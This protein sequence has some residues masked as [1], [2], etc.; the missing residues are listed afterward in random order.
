MMRE[1]FFRDL[2]FYDKDNLPD[3][4]FTDL[5]RYYRRA[6]FVPEYI[7]LS[8]MAAAALCKWMRA[9]YKYAEICRNM[10]P[11]IQQLMEAEEELNKAQAILGEKRVAANRI[12]SDLENRIH[13]HKEA[14][15]KAKQIE[16]QI[17]V[18]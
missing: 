3:D 7:G 5:G 16:K 1:N 12:K 15:K 10:K 17:Q 18:C 2:E 6:E 4:I 13:A 8:S 14:V 11:K 9:V